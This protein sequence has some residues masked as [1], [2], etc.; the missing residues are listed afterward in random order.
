MAWHQA[1]KGLARVRNRF[2]VVVGA[3][4]AAVMAPVKRHNMI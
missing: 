2:A 4:L 3:V 1:H